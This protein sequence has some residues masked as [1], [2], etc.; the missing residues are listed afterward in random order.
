MFCYALAPVECGGA[1]SKRLHLLRFGAALARIPEASP[2]VQA[3]EETTMIQIRNVPESLHRLLKSRAALEGL[4]MSDYL[5]RDIRRD[6]SKPT[7]K[8]WLDEL[9]RTTKPRKGSVGAA[10][11]IRELR[12][13]LPE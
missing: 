5:L 8:E 1:V 13:P 12:G 9:H 10:E 2:A 3:A 6:A 7:M 4:S 11:I